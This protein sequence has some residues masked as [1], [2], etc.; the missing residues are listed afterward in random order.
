MS[1]RLAD[2][3]IAA[4]HRLFV[5]RAAELELFQSALA[6]SDLPFCVLYVFGIGGVGKTTLL[7]E[8][9]RLCGQLQTPAI[10]LDARTIEPSPDSF[11]AALRR[12]MNLTPPDAPVQVLA[13]RAC[14][15]VLLIDTYETL[16]P[17]DA[18][19][20]D[21]FL[22]QLPENTLVVLAG[23]RPPAPA[24]LADGGWASL[25]R[26]LALGNLSQQESQAYLS[27]H[28]VPAEQQQA[29]LAFTHGHPLALALVADVVAQRPGIRLHPEAVPDV[30]Q[31]LL[32]QFR[33]H[34]PSVAHRAALQA[35]AVVRVTTEALLAEMLAMPDA[36]ALFEWLRGLSFIDAGPLGL[37]AHDLARETLAADL[38][39]RDRDGYAQL[40]RR[41]GMYYIKRLQQP[42]GWEQDRLLSDFMFL[43]R[44]NPAVRSLKP[45]FE[46]AEW[47]ESSGG[48]TDMAREND[49]PAIVAMVAQHE[50]EEAA[51]LA[52]HWLDRQLER[53]VVF[54]TAAAGAQ[55]ALAGFVLWVALHEASAE[56]VNADPATR[57]AWQYVRTH[58]PLRPG[59]GA[60]YR[61]FWMARDTYQAPSFIAGLVIVDWE[62][63][64]LTTPGLGPVFKA[65]ADPDLWTP[66]VAFAEIPRIE[67]ADFAV[68]GRRYGVF[69]V[70]L[71]ALP[72]LAR[73][74]LLAEKLSAAPPPSFTQPPAVARPLAILSQEEF[75]AAVRDALRSFCQPDALCGNP[76]LRSRLVMPRVEASASEAERIAALRAVVQQAAEALQASPRQAKRYRALYHTYLQPAP[77][78]EK[79]AELLDVPFSTFRRHLQAGITRVVETLWQWEISRSEK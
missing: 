34:L 47:Q 53:A 74:T 8:F 56:E 32:Q 27:K 70:D 51:R 79:A 22:P 25:V 46:G 7:R 54:R 18:W 21:A 48:F 11:L 28:Q 9:A 44:Y 37:F 13:A 23:R 69:G 62:R 71:R 63:H 77:T 73:L 55:P 67:E 72:P 17:L 75:A 5:G 20:R 76:L 68:G 39:W 65:Y 19:L 12:A 10:Y 31:V 64:L 29:A 60:L 49:V 2:R 26:P 36:Y 6:A 4:R 38:R 1:S 35:C 57:A 30:L 14:R 59:E 50:G 41:A 42:G 52:V 66:I 33:E 15:H 3:L 61:R 40:S 24:W 78:Q 16:A 45:A 43:H 58:A